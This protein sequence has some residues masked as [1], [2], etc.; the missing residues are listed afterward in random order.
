MKF[1]VVLAITLAFAAVALATLPT[2]NANVKKG[3][4][5]VVC[6]FG[7]RF[8]KAKEVANK[9]E[10]SFI[11]LGPVGAFFAAAAYAK[12]EADKRRDYDRAKKREKEEERRESDDIARL[13]REQEK[14]KQ[15][16]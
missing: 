9:V 4:R 12:G 11:Q 2:G 3:P 10:K 7:N 8:R 14:L 6:T 5:R 15:K 13:V 1:V 16:K